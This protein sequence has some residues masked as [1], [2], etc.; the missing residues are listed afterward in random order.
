MK[1]NLKYLIFCV[2]LSACSMKKGVLDNSVTY[3]EEYRPQFH[4]TP[5]AKWMN[6]PNGLIYLNGNYHMF[7]QHYP[8]ST[9]WGPMHWG[10]AISK[11]L[12]HWDEQPIALYPD[13]LGWIFSGSAV[14]DE[15]NTSGLA[16]DGK[17][18]LVAIFTHHNQKLEK[19]G[20]KDY[21][22]QSLAYSLDEGKTWEKY[23]GNPVIKN[24]G[25]VDFRDPKVRWNDE[26]K[27]WILTLATKDR[28]TFFSSPNLIDWTKESEFGENIGAHGGVWECPDLFPLKVNGKEVWVLLVSINPGAPN[29]GSGTQYFVGDF[30][31][32][33]FTPFNTKTKWIDYGT[34]NY[35]GVT[36]SNTNRPI[37]LGWMSNW[38]YAQQVPTQKWRSAM[39]LP[40]EL[41]LEILDDEF[42]LV[43]KPVKELKQ[44]I[45]INKSSKNIQIA[46]VLDL[47]A[48]IADAKGKFQLKF[49]SAT[50]QN[51]KIVLSNDNDEELIIGYNKKDNQYFID[52]Q[53]ARKQIFEKG[54]GAVHTAPRLSRSN[55]TDV[56]LLFD[57]ASVEFFADGGLTAMTDIFFPTKPFNKLH[58]KSKE[59]MIL[60]TL[61]IA[62]VQS[63]WD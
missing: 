62:S 30:D 49:N 42:L 18:P 35:A 10:H 39:T 36:F 56:Q 20:R 54:F 24:P 34:D 5:K 63:I 52:R 8:D 48:K 2:L 60:R 22:Y 31:G 3:K 57:A 16:K 9:V 40:R 12:I 51:Y 44:I 14:Y 50:I 38:Q 15:G 61:E 19:E 43:N 45:G 59:G 4:F 17:M 1:T 13:S 53:N 7:F 25:I 41:S 37:F 29:G 27:K 23:A 6:D 26:V 55:S 21:Q 32:K 46:D 33:T 58:I 11:D 47:T 28:I